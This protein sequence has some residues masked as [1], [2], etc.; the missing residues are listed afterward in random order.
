MR[1]NTP[2]SNIIKIDTNTEYSVVFFLHVIL[3]NL[4]LSGF[5]NQHTESTNKPALSDSDDNIQQ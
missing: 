4:Y 3:Q 5:D 2:L 1:V